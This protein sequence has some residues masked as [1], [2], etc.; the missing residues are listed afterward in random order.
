MTNTGPGHFDNRTDTEA[1]VELDMSE[2][3][4][5][6][7]YETFEDLTRKLLAVP[8]SEVAAEYA[9]AAATVDEA[10]TG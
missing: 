10:E 6:S 2:V 5:S 9:A 3:G 7:D 4:E 1:T 8:K